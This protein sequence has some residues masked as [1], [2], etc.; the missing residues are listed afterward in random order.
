LVAQARLG[1][2]RAKHETFFRRMLA[3]VDDYHSYDQEAPVKPD[4]N[5]YYKIAKPGE[6]PFPF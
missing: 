4:E 5:G 2:S 1:K 6:E 3:N